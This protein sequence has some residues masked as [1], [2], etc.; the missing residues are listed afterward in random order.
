MA[1]AGL[2]AWEA[3][4]VARVVCRVVEQIDVGK[5]DTPDQE[6]AEQRGKYRSDQRFQS[7]GGVGPYTHSSSDNL[8]LRELLLLSPDS[9]AGASPAR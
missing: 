8:R 4:G 2:V 9:P 7:R 3:D 1:I 5:A 6:P